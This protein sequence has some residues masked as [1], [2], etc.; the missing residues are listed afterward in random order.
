MTIETVKQ[1][2]PKKKISFKETLEEFEPENETEGE[3]SARGG[4]SVLKDPINLSD[5]SDSEEEDE[6]ATDEACEDLTDYILARDRVR[7]KIK[8]PSKFGD[9]DLVAYALASSEAIEIEEPKSYQEARR[10][11]DWGLWNGA[12]SE[13]MVSHDVN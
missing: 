8:P 1:T 4:V 5:S 7:R 3:S 10:S 13:E 11:K 6:L 12:M 9:T 2:S